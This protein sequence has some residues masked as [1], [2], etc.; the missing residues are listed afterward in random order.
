[1]PDP[2][3]QLVYRNLPQAESAARLTFELTAKARRVVRD[4]LLDSPRDALPTWWR[5]LPP[6]AE[7]ALTD[8]VRWWP[9]RPPAH[10]GRS[11]LEALI[12]TP[13]L[14]LEGD[15]AVVRNDVLIEAAEAIDPDGIWLLAH[16]QCTTAALHAL[17]TSGRVSVDL[18]P[19]TQTANSPL[20][21]VIARSLAD[22]ATAADLA[23]LAQRIRGEV[24]QGERG[25]ALRALKDDVQLLATLHTPDDP[26]LSA[27]VVTRAVASAH[28]LARTD[29]LASF[30]STEADAVTGRADAT[31]TRTEALRLLLASVPASSGE[32]PLLGTADVDTDWTVPAS[33]AA[34][35][36]LGA[37]IEALLDTRD[38]TAFESPGEGELPSL[39]RDALILAGLWD[40]GW[41][42]RWAA[43]GAPSPE[44]ADPFELLLGYP[45]PRSKPSIS[46]LSSYAHGLHDGTAE[47]YG[48]VFSP[49]DPFSDRDD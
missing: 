12:N 2:F 17:R 13:V 39:W 46:P 1:M 20:R 33:L 47:S 27:D 45:E 6:D 30:Q 14:R 41:A 9:A 28:R 31:V 38:W 34:L 22:V 7:R 24:L 44:T 19:E 8:L 21:R 36:E 48:D 3:S 37:A 5:H 10:T 43:I 4:R 29:L 15:E 32:N 49:R 35:P 42:A 25:A 40:E 26:H 11:I 16:G 18:L 23:H